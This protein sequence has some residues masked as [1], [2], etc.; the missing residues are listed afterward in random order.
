[1][2][3]PRLVLLSVLLI[4]VAPSQADK[5]TE[6]HLFQYGRTNTD[7]LKTAFYD[8]RDLL[9]EKL[10]MLSAELVQEVNIPAL[11]QLRL[12][13]VIGENGELLRPN[14]R[15]GSLDDK[16]QYWSETGALGVLTGYVTLQ[17]T[18]PYV[19]TTFYW[20]KLR[21]AYLAETITLKLPVV[22][23]SFDS[24]YDSHSV[25]TL[26]ALAHEIKQGCSNLSAAIYLLSEAHKRAQAV[27]SDFPEF[28]AELENIV[29]NAI[30][31][32]RV[33]CSD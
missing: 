20:G 7:Q 4:W 25:A 33:D 29:V 14:T 11:S 8:F 23:E 15:V 21:G 3:L 26:Y 30:N 5:R 13:P 1:M 19:H 22:G 16:R 10:P 18:I 28:G 32:L 17:E 27:S 31:K 24:T 6:L 12:N 9:S 2:R